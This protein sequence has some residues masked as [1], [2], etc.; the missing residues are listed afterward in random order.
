MS[1]CSYAWAMA[2]VIACSPALSMV[3]PRKGRYAA[4]SAA[5]FRLEPE[6][7]TRSST[8]GA[9][10]GAG[11]GVRRAR[12]SLWAPCFTDGGATSS[13]PGL[14]LESAVWAVAAMGAPSDVAAS[15]RVSSFFME[16]PLSPSP[17]PVAQRPTRTLAPMAGALIL[18]ATFTG[19]FAPLR[20]PA[21]A[22]AATFSGWLT[23]ATEAPT[24]EAGARVGVMATPT[25]VDV[26]MGPAWALTPVAILRLPDDGAGATRLDETP[27]ETRPEETLKPVVTVPGPVSAAARTVVARETA[28][29]DVDLENALL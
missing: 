22:D 3:R 8:K 9:T 1:L 14:I 20:P 26:E 19:D 13:R 10:S 5:G 7:S 23:A 24:A 4:S 17:P 15:A 28:A 6:I 2:S 18:T 16:S 29:E 27:A 12:F 21:W 11:A 25:W